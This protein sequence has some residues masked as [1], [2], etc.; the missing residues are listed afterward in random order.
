MKQRNPTPTS[1]GRMSWGFLWE[2]HPST[3]VSRNIPSMVLQRPGKHDEELFVVRSALKYQKYGAIWGGS[4][5]FN[6][7]QQTP[8][9]RSIRYLSAPP[10]PECPP[11]SAAWAGAAFSGNQR[12]PIPTWLIYWN[13]ST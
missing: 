2:D 6:H 1:S 9:P 5:T 11:S 3:L 7:S 12:E 10:V 13:M 8:P 4:H